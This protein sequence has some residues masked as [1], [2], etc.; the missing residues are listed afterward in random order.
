MQIVATKSGYLRKVDHESIYQLAKKKDAILKVLNRPGQFIVEGSP[1][2]LVWPGNIIDKEIEKNVISA[3]SLGKQR[4]SEH[5]AEFAVD[6]LV[7][8]AVRSLSPGI[9]DPFTAIMCIDQLS[10][11]LCQ[12]AERILP[13]GYRYDEKNQLRV[14]AK[15][16][17]FADILNSAFNQIRQY[18][19]E[20]A[21]V[22]IRLLEALIAIS[23]HLQNEE[24][25]SALKRHADMI[26]R[27]SEDGLPEEQDREDLNK[28]YQ[29]LLIQMDRTG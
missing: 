12:I 21:A 19:R 8:I 6:Q 4:S 18:G 3:F 28:R 1:I 29:A 24:D 10:T 16:T 17:T 11:R 22:T 13:R 7:E 26:M 20:S 25:K 23:S 14:I 2:V 5:D 9:N 27:G 15:P